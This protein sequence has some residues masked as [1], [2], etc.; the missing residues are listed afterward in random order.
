MFGRRMAASAFFCASL[1]AAAAASAEIRECRAAIEAEARRLGIAVEALADAQQ[2]R[3][4]YSTEGPVGAG[5]QTYLYPGTC[6]GAIVVETT[7]GCAV[8]R[9]YATGNCDLP[10]GR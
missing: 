4:F 1:L 7:R 6:R 8:Q 9:T 10:R 3:N 2:A 5:M